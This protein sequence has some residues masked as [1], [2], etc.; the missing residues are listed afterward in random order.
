MA[1]RNFDDLVDQF[2]QRIYASSKGRLRLAILDRDLQAHCPHLDPTHADF[3]PLQIL[4]A[5]CGHAHVSLSLAQQGH[6]LTLCDISA[7]LLQ[8]ARAAFTE[9]GLSGNAQFHHS[10]IQGLAQRVS[11]PAAGY[12]LV[13]CHAVMEWVADPQVLLAQLVQLTRPG[14]WL[15]LMFFNRH[16]TVLRKLIRGY[17]D[18]ALRGQF[19]G[20]GQGLTPLNPLEPGQ[21]YQW[22]DAQ[23]VT[24]ACCSG[25]RVFHDYMHKD[26]RDRRREEDILELE[27]RYSQ[28][29]PYR[30][31]GRY[32]HVLMQR[33][34]VTSGETQHE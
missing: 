24:V 28:I 26:I 25:I 33:D 7:R 8:H 4:D 6:H 23:P 19:A 20:K 10:D 17:L 9:A 34:D 32:V 16:S 21:V 14:G 15:S 12:D 27:K 18:E 1:D 31:L 11:K 2:S 3:R 13:L 29:E 30:S 22:I 5:G